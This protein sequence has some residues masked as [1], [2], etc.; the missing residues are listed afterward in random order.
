VN[1]PL[2]PPPPK[3]LGRPLSDLAPRAPKAKPTVY[4]G[5]EFRSRLEAK[6]ACFFDQIGWRWT[7]EPFDGNGYIPDFSLGERLLTEV[8]PAV[9]KAQYCAAIPR[10]TA[11]L[12]GHWENDLLI[13]GVDPL[14]AWGWEPGRTPPMGLV[15]RRRDGGWDFRVAL[16]P[17][18]TLAE[19]RAAWAEATNVTKWRR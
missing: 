4:A 16:W 6:W 8:K 13:V 9:S 12:E 11:G 14:P 3:P 10:M 15:G 17:A 2:L 19:V 1:R 18:G 7:Y 5:I